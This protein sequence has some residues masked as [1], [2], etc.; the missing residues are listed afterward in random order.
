M[1]EIIFMGDFKGE[2]KISYYIIYSF[3][4]CNFDLM[5]ISLLFHVYYFIFHIKKMNESNLY[6]MCTTLNK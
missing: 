6:N 1:H 3:R 5:I 4:C 2:T